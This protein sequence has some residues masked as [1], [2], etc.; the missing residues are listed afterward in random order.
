MVKFVVGSTE[1]S[2][3]IHKHL[4]YETST[5]FKC[6]FEEGFSQHGARPLNLPDEDPTTFHF[7]V[8]WLYTRKC[9]SLSAWKLQYQVINSIR[10][11]ETTQ[12]NTTET[13]AGS[14]KDSASNKTAPDSLALTLYGLA[15]TEVNLA[16]NTARI[17]EYQAELV[18]LY[19]FADRRDVPALRNAVMDRFVEMRMRQM[20]LVSSQSKLV[21]RA[22]ECLPRHA[23]LITYLCMEAALC[24]S[25]R[26]RPPTPRSELPG[27]FLST[28]MR[29]PPREIHENGAV[30]T[31][32]LC[33][34]T[35]LCTLHTHADAGEIA[36]CQADSAL[37]QGA[38]RKKSPIQL[39]TVREPT[40][41]PRLLGI[42]VHSQA[43]C[44]VSVRP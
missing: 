28:V 1:L 37:L 40:R 18:E 3:T 24:W 23:C 11:A 21:V 9:I 17:R 4:M 44:A 32:Y 41:I 6:V 12:D 13:R 14:S 35:D 30:L 31:G 10:N 33:W 25:D 5:N 22:Y 38:V 2:F 42:A 19:L 29:N 26:T 36:A 43:G 7:F 39:W 34:D 16:S 27:E 8:N 15:P 20:P